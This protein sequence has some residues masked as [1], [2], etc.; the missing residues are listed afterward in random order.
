MGGVNGRTDGPPENMMPSA[1]TVVDEGIKDAV[2]F[3]SRCSVHAVLR[4][5][6]RLYATDNCHSTAIML[7][8]HVSG[9]S[10]DISVTTGVSGTSSFYGD[11]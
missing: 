3:G 10:W 1:Y 2:H 4:L 7:L 6:L 8:Q 5:V 11:L 9:T